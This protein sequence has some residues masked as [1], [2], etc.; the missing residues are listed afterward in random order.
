M[1]HESEKTTPSILISMQDSTQNGGSSP[2]VAEK[3]NVFTE[4]QLADVM[5]VKC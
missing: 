1:V 2:I 5:H 3:S 4:A